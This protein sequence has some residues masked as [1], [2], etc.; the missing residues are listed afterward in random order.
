MADNQTSN[1]PDGETGGFSRIDPVS[2]IGY[3]TT[4]GD[5]QW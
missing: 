3:R 5:K 2:M 4:I 1:I